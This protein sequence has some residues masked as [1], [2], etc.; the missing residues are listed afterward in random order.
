MT[1]SIPVPHIG[2]VVFVLDRTASM[3]KLDCPDGV[4]RW[5]FAISALRATLNDMHARDPKQPVK[6]LTCGR[7]VVEVEGPALDETIDIS[8]GDASF[9]IGQAALEA[10]WH[11]GEGHVIIIA[12]GPSA[13]DTRVGE[14]VLENDIAM[15]ALFSRTYFLTVGKVDAET[16]A[17]AGKWPQ[18]DSL[19][20]TLHLASQLAD[21]EPPTRIEYMSD[22]VSTLETF[23]TAPTEP[24]PDLQADGS[25]PLVKSTTK[26]RGR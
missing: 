18:S 16:A 11:A 2:P 15:R 5:V 4:S 7:T 12:D 3:A 1:T 8:N 6:L 10:A 20:D 21:V 17:F 25:V 13:Q 19:E 14:L 26:K 22:G 23:E 9:A 24:P